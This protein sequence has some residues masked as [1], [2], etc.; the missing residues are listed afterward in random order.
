MDTH[1]TQEMHPRDLKGNW[2]CCGRRGV[3]INNS[4][5]CLSLVMR[6]CDVLISTTS[7][8]WLIAAPLILDLIMRGYKAKSLVI[9][10]GVSINNSRIC[11]LLVMRCY[12]A[13]VLLLAEGV[14]VNSSRIF[15]YQHWCDVVTFSYPLRLISGSL[16]LPWY[17]ISPCEVTIVSGGAAGSKSWNNAWLCVSLVLRYCDSSTSPPTPCVYLIGASLIRDVILRCVSSGEGCCER[18]Q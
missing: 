18:L 15:V 2:R 1:K 17:V 3:S 8:L 13:V 6:C 16:L 10:E 12:K 9:A 11:L 5:I 14:S 4:R 7:C